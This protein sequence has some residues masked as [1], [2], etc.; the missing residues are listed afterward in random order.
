MAEQEI[1]LKKQRMP[2]TQV[3]NELLCNN[4]ISGIAKAMWCVFY[5]KPDGWT[6]YWPEIVRNFREGREAL[7]R[8]KKELEKAGYLKTYLKKTYSLSLKWKISLTKF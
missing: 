8:A 7:F 2:F 3:P 4:L 5:S 1:T 6:F